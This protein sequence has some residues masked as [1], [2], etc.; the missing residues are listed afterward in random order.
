M[1]EQVSLITHW[2]NHIF[3]PVALYL[4]HVL[5]IQPADHE[6][7][8]PEYVVM[9]LVVL[10]LGTVLALIL[11]SRLSVERPG[12]M[13]QV[14]ELLFTNPLKFGIC[15]LLDENVGHGARQHVAVVGTVSVFILFSNLLSVF[16]AFSAPTGIV[17]VP[18]A[19]AS[20]TFVYFNWQGIRHHGTGHYLLTFAGSPRKLA[21]W[22]LGILLFPV[23]LFS[24][25]ARILSLTARLWANIFASDMLYGIMLSL[26]VKLTLFCWS[27]FAVLGA[28]LA[29]LPAVI[30]L[31]FIA[32]HMF[33]AVIQA[34]VFTV[35]PTIYIGMATADE[36]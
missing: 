21:D 22:L 11:R 36:H 23:E 25:A 28:A 35:L 18:L 32:L 12:G 26:L 30:P 9:S 8:I 20:V 4:L 14:A 15:D 13:Q 31:A 16:P 19:C 29:I 34:Y 5:K 3:G 2:V 6:T 1:E 10:V 24:T 7:P 27:K 33:V 17:V